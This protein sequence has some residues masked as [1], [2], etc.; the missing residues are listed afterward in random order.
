[1]PINMPENLG[2]YASS[3]QIKT[4]SVLFYEGHTQILFAYLRSEEGKFYVF[5]QINKKSINFL[6]LITASNRN[7]G[8]YVCV[9]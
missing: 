6:F 7:A 9:D 5:Y 2:C 1:M 8:R 3:V 4:F